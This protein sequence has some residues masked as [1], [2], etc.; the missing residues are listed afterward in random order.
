MK[1]ILLLYG[2][3]SE[4]PLNM[5]HHL[6]QLLLITDKSWLTILEFLPFQ[7]KTASLNSLQMWWKDRQRANEEPI[8]SW[9]ISRSFNFRELVVLGS[10]LC[11]LSAS[12]Y[13]YSLALQFKKLQ[14]VY[15]CVVLPFLLTTSR[16]PSGRADT[17]Y[18]SFEVEFTWVFDI[19]LLVFSAVWGGCVL[20]FI[21]CN[22][23][24]WMVW[25]C[26]PRSWIPPDKHFLN[27]TYLVGSMLF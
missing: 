21:M 14:P 7:L 10:S 4:S 18:W 5:C 1:H 27:K 16:K 11:S 6:S 20:C 23:F 8:K 9:C 2:I 15:Q 25:S 17:N 12:S 13:K 26:I 19:W 22:T 24:E 3:F